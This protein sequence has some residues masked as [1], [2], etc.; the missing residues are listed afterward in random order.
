[1]VSISESG[2]QNV[3]V[4][5]NRE[6][7]ISLPV[8]WSLISAASGNWLMFDEQQGVNVDAGVFRTRVPGE[9]TAAYLRIQK[10]EKFYV[11]APFR[12]GE[13]T[14]SHRGQWGYE[15]R[16]EEE[17][18]WTFQGRAYLY[19]DMMQWERNVYFATA[20]QGG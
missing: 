19:T 17:L 16:R 4:P 2:G 1:M 5:D 15:C 3:L 18:L 12:F 11:E 14:I 20:G 9:V 8:R 6:H 10:P 7:P 13:L